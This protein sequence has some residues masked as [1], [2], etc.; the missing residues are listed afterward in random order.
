MVKPPL[1]VRAIPGLFLVTALLG[2]G[3]P[4]GGRE[5]VSGEILF[6]GKPLD[7]GTIQFDPTEG[8]GTPSGG[9]IQ[10]G[11]YAVEKMK[12]LKPGKYKVLISSG[13]PKQHAPP[14][15]LPGAPR[16]VFKERL[17]KEYNTASTQVVE[18]KKGEPNRFDFTIP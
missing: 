2:C 3:D 1:L 8:Q 16:P 17:P 4:S 6:K 13:D 5:A 12:G 14:E 10:Q 18:A 7:Q 15:E 9:M 11:K